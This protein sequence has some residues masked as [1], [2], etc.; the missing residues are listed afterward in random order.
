M[1]FGKPLHEADPF[2]LRVRKRSWE[3]EITNVACSKNR[4][5]RM[6]SDK[7]DWKTAGPNIDLIYVGMKNK[8]GK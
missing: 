1:V 3:K 2:A 6:D 7:M 4:V 5:P 8:E